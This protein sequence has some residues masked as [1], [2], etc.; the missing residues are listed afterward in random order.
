MWRTPHFR[1][2]F[3]SAERNTITNESMPRIQ[4]RAWHLRDQMEF[5]FGT[6]WWYNKRNRYYGA[7]PMFRLVRQLVGLG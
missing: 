5:V 1:P 6:Y 3:S 7:D 4:F 2:G